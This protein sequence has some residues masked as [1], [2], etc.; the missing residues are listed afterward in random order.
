[1][2]TK[3][4]KRNFYIPD[5]YVFNSGYTNS[6]TVIALSPP[7]SSLHHINGLRPYYQQ[8]K[9]F[10]KLTP[11]S[12][13]PPVGIHITDDLSPHSNNILGNTSLTSDEVRINI[14][15]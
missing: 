3:M 15:E 9:L 12:L 14:V 2:T 11:S 5:S 1:M 7:V 13:L 6:A 10:S 4:I 8:N